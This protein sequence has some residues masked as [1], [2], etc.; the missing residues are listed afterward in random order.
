MRAGL[1]TNMGTISGI[2]TYS[3]IP[4]DPMMPA[5]VVQLGLFLTTGV[6]SG[7][8]RIQL[9][10]DGYFRQACHVAGATNLDELI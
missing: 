2:R 7:P 1:A 10:G 8:H 6:C 4:D 3:D 5:A 9:C